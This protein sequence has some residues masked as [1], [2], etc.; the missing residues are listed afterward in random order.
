MR[1]SAHNL[2]IELGRYQNLP[3]ANRLCTFCKSEIG[4]E[5]HCLMKCLHPTLTTLRNRYLSDVFKINHQLNKLSRETFLKYILLASD[6]SI[7]KL[8]G[9]YFFDVINVFLSK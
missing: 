5:I 6:Y 1:I 2:P 8:T 7:I 3:R 4:N 9:Q